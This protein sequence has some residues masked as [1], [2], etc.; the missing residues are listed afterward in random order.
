MTTEPTITQKHLPGAVLTTSP[1]LSSGRV[2]RQTRS[3]QGQGCGVD[4]HS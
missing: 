1:K 4:K 3:G 2:E